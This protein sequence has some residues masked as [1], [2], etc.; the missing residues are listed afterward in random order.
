[1]SFKMI[2][3][4]T[5]VFN[6]GKIISSTSSSYMPRLD[7]ST[8]SWGEDSGGALRA[9]SQSGFR[10]NILGPQKRCIVNVRTKLG[11][12]KKHI[13]HRDTSCREPSPLSP[14]P[15]LSL[16]PRLCRCWHPGPFLAV[17]WWYC[18]NKLTVS[19]TVRY[20]S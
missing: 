16:A 5:R 19:T 6:T 17:T 18:D 10:K 2:L 8:E 9:R 12:K 13:V 20:N 14:S 15:V 1:M 7:A 4:R 11:R 3:R